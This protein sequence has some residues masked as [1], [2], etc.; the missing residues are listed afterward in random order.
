SNRDMSG[1]SIYTSNTPRF[2][3]DAV[4]KWNF[5]EN[6][7]LWF[8]QTKLPGNRERVISSGDMQFVDRSILNA[9]FN[10]DRDVGIQLRHH[11]NL[12]NSFVVREII[13]ISQG[14][15]RNVTTGNLGGFQYTGRVEVLPFGT[16]QS[17]GDYVGSS[18]ERPEKSKLSVGLTYDF[19]NDA[20]K[21][22]SNLGK[23]MLTSTGFHK[24]NIT[25]LFIDAMYKCKGFSFMG[26]YAK[27]DADKPIA[28][29]EAGTPTGDIVYVG[30]ALNLQAG[31]LF[32]NNWELSGRYSNV[33]PEENITGT[34][35]IN[36]YTLGV[37]KYIVG[38]KLKVQT[39]ISYTDI[40]QLNNSVTYRLQFDV[41]F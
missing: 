25:T 29:E 28:T 20:V 37:S 30:Q 19:N 41:H 7:V 36:Q 21:T 3:Y 14:E 39:D 1:A 38:H 4:M 8:G 11:F 26:E 32:A 24:T 12:S 17:K 40:Q 35:P 5:H 13:A 31:Y 33:N 9:N 2:V 34:Q 10:I 6:F 23:Y 18:I 22:R 15:G 27:R 16:F